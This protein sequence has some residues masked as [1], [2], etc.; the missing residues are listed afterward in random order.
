MK[1]TYP[2]REVFLI[3]LFSLLGSSGVLAQN[4]FYTKAY[5][6]V[7]S[8]DLSKKSG[9]VGGSSYNVDG[10][11][12]FGFLIGKELSKKWEIETGLNIASANITPIIDFFPQQIQASSV[13]ITRFQAYNFPLLM[14]YN[15]L[16]FLYINAGPIIT[17]DSSE[18]ILS[19]PSGRNQSGVGYLVGIGAQHYFNKIGFFIH[20]H[21]KRHGTVSF[22]SAN[23]NLTELGV[24]VG[25]GY[26]FL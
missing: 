5:Y 8:T 13:A 17:I 26:K 1:N 22:E 23:Y 14:R 20:P 16:P 10:F 3:F 24:Q 21:F 19:F 4:A 6:G 11:R 7:S 9:F 25:V 15:F 18:E 2:L 12:E